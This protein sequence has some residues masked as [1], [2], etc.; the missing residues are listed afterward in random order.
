MKRKLAALHATRVFFASD[1]PSKDGTLRSF[2]YMS[3]K[4]PEKR[5][6]MAQDAAA[7]VLQN[8]DAV[9]W[10]MFDKTVLSVDA[11]IQAML[12]KD[13]CMDAEAFII[14]PDECI[15]TPSEFAISIGKARIDVGKAVGMEAWALNETQNS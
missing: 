15:G 2:S 9:T 10:E 13:I 7:H 1:A 11:G 14:A 6:R 5:A 4:D 12:D 3:L 8:L